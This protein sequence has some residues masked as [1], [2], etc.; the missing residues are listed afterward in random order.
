MRCS[1]ARQKRPQPRNTCPLNQ[2]FPFLDQTSAKYN[3][4]L[5]SVRHLYHQPF[6]FLAIV[7]G[8]LGPDLADCGPL[9]RYLPHYLACRRKICMMGPSRERE[10]TTDEDCLQKPGI[11]SWSDNW[12]GDPGK[13]GAATIKRTPILN[14]QCHRT[15]PS[16]LSRTGPWLQ[17]A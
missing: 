14:Q 11:K 13:S 8:P 7:G 6:A 17:V 15:T 1:T 9:R 4:K 3:S 2:R 10:M 12:W 5:R 16:L